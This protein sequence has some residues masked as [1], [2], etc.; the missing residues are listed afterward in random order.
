MTVTSLK[1]AGN[2]LQGIA[3]GAAARGSANAGADF[4]RIWEGQNSAD[5]R[6]EAKAPAAKRGE[7]QM[8]GKPLKARE[9]QAF[10]RDEAGVSKSSDA[11]KGNALDEAEQ[12]EAMEAMGTA[13]A[14]LVERIADVLCI[15]PE[16][17]ENILSEM[18]LEPVDLLDQTVFNEFAL[19]AV[20]ALD[21]S[22]LLTQGELYQDFKQLLGEWEAVL[23]GDS[24]IRDMSLGGLKEWMAGHRESLQADAPAVVETPE[25]IIEVTVD[26]QAA[27]AGAKESAGTK[28]AAGAAEWEAVGTVPG[29][30][31]DIAADAAADAQAAGKRQDA[32]AGE[33]AGAGTGTA[34]A[35][36]E[37]QSLAEQEIT[38]PKQ[39]AGQGRQEGGHSDGQKR[40]AHR[41]DTPIAPNFQQAGVQ[42]A[43]LQNVQAKQAAAGWSADTQDIMRQIMDYMKIQV[44]PDVTSLEMQL[45]PASLGTLQIHVASKGGVLTA[46]FVAQNE[47]VKAALES[48]MVQ[49]KDNFAQQGVKVEAIEVTV[50]T[51]QFEGNLEQGQRGSGNQNP[52]GRRPRS[53]RIT[54]DESLATEALSGAQEQGRLAQMPGAVGSTVDYTA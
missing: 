7:A 37:P 27:E 6:Q 31:A 3:A 47:A 36:K 22:A 38:L 24:G 13:A 5:A 14:V 12:E 25:P 49:L 48:Q 2:A 54:P 33:D 52:S 26:A 39:G 18:N 43:A 51:H 53:R 42:N 19:K 30:A 16:E 1:N 9:A 21:A 45:H 8:P 44:K 23:A 4:Q 40:M 20:G 15:S 10:G 17:V 29:E 46:N 32:D 11:P 50:Q 41:A 28:E 35:R 34:T